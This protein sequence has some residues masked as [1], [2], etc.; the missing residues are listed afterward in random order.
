MEGHNSIVLVKQEDIVELLSLIDRS[1][2]E[3]LPF[4]EAAENHGSTYAI[5][6]GGKTVGVACI[7]EGPRA[8]LYVYVFPEYRNRGYGEAAAEIA[9][10]ILAASSPIRISTEYVSGCAAAAR[11]AEKNG[12]V[13]KYSSA[14][15]EYGGAAF[16][17]RELPIRHYRDEDY[18]E[19]FAMYAWAFHVMRLGTGCFPDSVAAQPCEK[20]RRY[21]A[22]HANDGYVY[23]DGDEIVGHARIDGREIGVVS[24]KLSH[25]GRG[26]GRGFVRFLINRILERGQKPSLWCVVGNEKAR[27]LYESLGFH[28]I[29]RKDFAV[30][31]MGEE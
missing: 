15:M 19:A 2:A 22:E 14:L 8:F 10:R 1:E 5:L 24:V 18:P 12:F 21:W 30:K 27:G 31:R 13:R 28:E 11:L 29:Y 26:I 20:E 3:S 7:K 17:E 9:E 16:P 4:G 25:Q 6:C 23:L